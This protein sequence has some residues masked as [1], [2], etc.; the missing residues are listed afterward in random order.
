[1]K[2][3]GRSR[4]LSSRVRLAATGLVATA[5][6]AGG[7][8]LSAGSASAAGPAWAN[9]SVGIAL[10]PPKVIFMG[11]YVAQ[12]KG[13]FAREHLHVN[14]IS[15]PNGLQTELGT[16]SGSINFGFSS[17][18]DAIESAA[19]GAPI[20]A[21]AS[22][23]STLDTE[24]IAAPGIATA[25]DLIGQ[26]VGSTGVDGFSVTTLAACLQPAGVTISQTSPI[27]MTRSEFVPALETGRIKVAVFHIDDAYVVLHGLPGATV[28]EKQYTA[29]PNW[30][31]GGITTLNS[32]AKSHVDVTKRF[33]TAMVLAN[34][35]MNN[36]KNTV[37]LISIGVKQ[38]GEDR[39]AVAN[40]VQF[41]QNAHTW[42]N[43]V[44]L[45]PVSE[46]FTAVKLFQL[47]TITTLPTYSQVVDPSYM[48]AVIAKMGAVPGN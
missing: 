40:A 25:K 5:T 17:A 4:A 37:S 9:I 46:H 10:S 35:W 8:M 43:N 15:M 12:V 32:Y 6:L 27:T 16:T 33:L 7:L 21:I 26:P 11:P 42:P 18:T 2:N 23:G 3:A 14:F 28:L 47:K 34:R 39:G 22:Y 30:W 45:S 48:K 1:M 13:F 29:L 44:G 31:Y 19:V 20:R 38:T 24:C 36:R 41:L